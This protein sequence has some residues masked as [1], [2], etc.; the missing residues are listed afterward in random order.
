MLNKERKKFRKIVFDYAKKTYGSDPEYLW[1]KTPDS[2]VLRHSSNRKWYAVVLD[3]QKCR[4]GLE[5]DEVIDI[6]DVKCEPMLIGSLIEKDGYFRAYHMNKEKW[7]TIILDGTVPNEEIFGLIDLSYELTA[8]GNTHRK[9]A[10][11]R[12]ERNK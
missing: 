11:K 2:A 8:V 6:L 9:N 5:G 3:V 12:F 7:I 1:T 4:L 10:H